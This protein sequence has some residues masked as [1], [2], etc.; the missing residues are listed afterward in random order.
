M[1]SIKVRGET[2]Q[3]KQ[4]HC[5]SFFLFSLAVT[6]NLT[7]NK[8][9]DPSQSQYLKSAIANFEKIT[10]VDAVRVVIFSC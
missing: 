10:A 6:L 7:C 4:I 3:L 8:S 1:V 9:L 2:H 5:Q